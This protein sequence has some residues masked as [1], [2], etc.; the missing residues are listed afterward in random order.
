MPAPADHP[1]ALIGY[2]PEA[3]RALRD[4]GLIALNVPT[5]DLP[6]V[7]DACRTLE[8]TG[9]LVHPRLENAALDGVTPDH[10]AQ[11]LGRVDAIAFAGGGHLGTI[12]GVHSLA[13][14]LTD[15]VQA[16]GYATR[17]ASALLLGQSSADLTQAMPLARLGFGMV[18]VCADSAPEA[19]RA[20]RDLPAGVRGYPFSRRDEAIASFAERADLIVLTAGNLPPG[21]LQPYHTLA[22]LTGR[23]GA[24]SSG[25]SALDLSA[26]PALRLARQLAHAT[27]QRFHAHDLAALVP[28]FQ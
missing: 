8:F 19:E 6:R 5:T 18:G 2:A 3:A 26:L 14:A 24:G 25:A 7:L 4:L 20:L 15:A 22:D 21:T 11:R 28:A 27:G 10:A 23:S 16:S 17:G 1:L 9:A 12:H 13:D